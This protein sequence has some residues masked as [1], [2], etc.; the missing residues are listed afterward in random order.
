MKSAKLVAAS[1]VLLSAASIAMPSMA[2]DMGKKCDDKHHAEGWGEQ[3]RMGGPDARH[4]GKALNLT[5]A[6]KETLKAQREADRPARDALHTKLKAAREALAAAVDAGA[7]DAE[8]HALSETVGKL[9]AEQ[10]LAGAKAQKAFVAVLTAEQKQALAEL[11]AKR[12]ERKMERKEKRES[13]KS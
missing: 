12:M 1:I 4:L 6:Q 13:A 11:K 9:H 10:A 3:G 7:N 8:L 5:D 2:G